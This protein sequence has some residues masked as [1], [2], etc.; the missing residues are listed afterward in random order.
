MKQ[1]IYTKRVYDTSEVK[2]CCKDGTPLS[3]HNWASK[4]AAELSPIF[5]VTIVPGEPRRGLPPHA[6]QPYMNTP[7]SSYGQ[8]NYQNQFSSSQTALIPHQNS[9]KSRLAYRDHSRRKREQVDKQSD[10]GSTVG[11]RYQSAPQQ[12]LPD[13][14]LQNP[15]Q[16]PFATQPQSWDLVA[17]NDRGR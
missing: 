15:T 8:S 14:E 17:L 4:L 10:Q 2:F 13:P 3:S 1:T 7:F 16:Q 5:R 11:K 9:N 6:M 12:N